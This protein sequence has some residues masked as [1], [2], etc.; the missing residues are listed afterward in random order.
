[1]NGTLVNSYQSDAYGTVD[2]ESTRFSLNQE[3]MK[4]NAGST[5]GVLRVKEPK[6][7]T[8]TSAAKVDQVGNSFIASHQGETML[9][10]AVVRFDSLPAVT[11]N[12]RVLSFITWEHKSYRSVGASS[13][14]TEYARFLCVDEYGNLYDNNRDVIM[15]DTKRLEAGKE[16][17]IVIVLM[18]SDS[19]C[20]YDL[21]L[22]G[23]YVFSS[24]VPINKGISGI[25]ESNIRVCDTQ[26][27]Y[28]I[29]IKK[30]S[31]E[32]VEEGFTF[33][34]VDTADWRGYQTTK[35]TKNAEGK[36]T[37]DL[38]L[39]SLVKT[40]EGYSTM[41]YEVTKAYRENGE[42]MEEVFLLSGNTLYTEINQNVNG[43][44]VAWRAADNGSK[45]IMAAVVEDMDASQAGYEL[46]VRPF[47]VRADGL[48][49]YGKS[50]YLAYS[51]LGSDG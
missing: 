45:Y 3:G 31:L 11:S 24:S 5:S 42:D 22:D 9:L 27:K 15:S 16:A 50:Q 14:S 47:A 17:E 20:L 19:A 37:F 39:V 1:M 10:T 30:L 23:E 33:G 12:G 41:G 18:P 44:T 6:T 28:D 13:T 48:R 32:T 46:R 8:I 2:L 40:I 34:K 7:Q 36:D 49:I 26:R 4:L 51:G 43:K 25:T 35:V 29:T 21:Y 38:R